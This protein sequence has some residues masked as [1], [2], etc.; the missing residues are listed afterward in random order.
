MFSQLDMENNGE[1]PITFFG[2][3][4]DAEVLAKNLQDFIFRQLLESFNRNR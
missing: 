3:D 4:S 1:I 2:H